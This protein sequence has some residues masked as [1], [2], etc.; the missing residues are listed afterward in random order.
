MTDTA[1]K[2]TFDGR[3]LEAQLAALSELAKRSPQVRDGLLRFFDSCEEFVRLDVD[4]RSAAVASEVIVRPYPS[5]AL[6]G[7]LSALGAGDSDL[8]LFEQSGAPEVE[9]SNENTT[10]HPLQSGG[11]P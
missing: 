3:A 8:L 1:L 9:S 11:C 6:F 10:S 5:D 2:L 4:S 7:L